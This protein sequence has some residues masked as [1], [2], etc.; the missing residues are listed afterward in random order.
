[1][2]RIKEINEYVDYVDKNPTKTN[3]L[4]KLLIKNIVTPVLINESVYFDEIK[5]YKCLKYCQ[6]NY[7]PLF[8]YQ[9]FIYA[10]FFMRYE[11][12]NLLVF[13]YFL[14]EMGRGNGKDGFI[15]PLANFFQTPLYGVKNYHIDIVANNEDQAK[16]T[17]LVV[18][19]VMDQDKFKN[20]FKVTLEEI[21]NLQTKARLR[22][23]TS[24]AKTKDGKKIGMIIFNEY[25]AYE[26]SEQ[27]SVFE[28]GLGKIKD[29]RKVI[30][31]TNGSVREGPLDELLEMC[32]NILKTGENPLG[33]F[34]FICMME[35][36]EEINN[37]ANWI[38]SNPSIEYMPILKNQIMLD[39]IEMQKM[40]SKRVEFITKRMNLS[41][42]NEE[43]TIA[44]WE[45]ILACCYSNV[46][47][48]VERELPLIEYSD[49]AIIG[50]DYADI[51]DFASAGLLFKIDGEY[52]WR[53]KTWI[54]KRSPFFN[55]I[56][57]P[58]E[59]SF[60]Q[61]GYTDYEICDSDTIPI[62]P[63]I[64]WCTDKMG[65]YQ[66][67]RILMDTYR[68]TLFKELFERSGISVYDRKTNRG[69]LELV[70]RLGAVN[71]LI[72][73][74]IENEITN[75]NVNL[76]NSS[77]MRWY[78]NNTSVKLDKYGNMSFGKIEPKLRKNDGFMAMVVA[79]YREELLIK[80]VV[81][82]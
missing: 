34:P 35:S 82:I 63:I 23:N 59:K 5:Y 28:S 32:I 81:Y 22:F 25:H 56:K 38:K 70:K 66:V 3:H 11:E 31:T 71:A 60:S 9:K 37:P 15:A 46:E 10:F 26:S 27:V 6:H 41:A 8:P 14:I 18:H 64:D 36:L 51:R 43:Q 54:C 30:I 20:K 78:I 47:K 73:P 61:Y 40:P 52:V 57:F 33:Y 4:I 76:G 79:M 67:K 53:Q 1:M 21:T 65:K 42:R 13:P 19:D 74:K 69:T 68:Y 50:I 48:K 12:T 24:N 77:L 80:R 72:G 58:M 7:Y 75:E 39:Y 62:Q 49:P 2:I 45:K 29:P 44:T 17:F 55:S 16:D